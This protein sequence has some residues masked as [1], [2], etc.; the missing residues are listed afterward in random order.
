MVEP[1]SAHRVVLLAQLLGD[2]SF[3]RRQPIRYASSDEANL[4]AVRE[5]ALAEFGITA[6]RDDYAAARV[7]TLRLPA[8][9]KLA[10]GRRNPI[11][12]WLDELGLFGARAAERFVPEPVFRLP[13]QQIALFLRHLWSTDGTV[14]VPRSGADG[15]IGYHSPSRRLLED[16]SLLLLRFGISTKLASRA[17]GSA[18]KLA[19]RASGYTLEI[20]GRDD[21][22]RFLREI[23]VHGS[24]SQAGAALLAALERGRGG[25]GIDTVPEALWSRVRSA[26]AERGLSHREFAAAVTRRLEAGGPGGA[27]EVAPLA[28]VAAVLDS[29]AMDLEATNDV[30]WD[31]ILGIEPLGAQEVYDATV[32][33]WHN[34]IANGIVTHNSIEQDADVVIMLHREDYYDK[35]SP[36]EGEADFIVAKHRNGPTGTVT[37]A[38][39]LHVS[40]FVDMAKD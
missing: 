39:L 18:A 36:R 22:L 33:R 17:S 24:R 16:V 10:R 12:E 20:T 23:G 15:R 37:V 4:G 13:K 2:G 19:S 34:F 28:R 9:F 26:L 31:E 21:Q 35:Q 8:P 11:A 40:C 5:A 30:Y 3:V 14:S 38:A 27:A 29:A 6:V 32:P 1:W 7:T 25:L